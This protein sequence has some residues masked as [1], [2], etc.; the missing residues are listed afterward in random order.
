MQD[1]KKK[2]ENP[3]FFFII[4]AH[5]QKGVTLLSFNQLCSVCVPGR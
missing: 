5:T 2:I 1:T 4:R 3:L